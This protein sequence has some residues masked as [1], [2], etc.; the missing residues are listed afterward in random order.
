MRPVIGIVARSEENEN[1][2]SMLY[3]FESIRQSIIS[4]G[5]EPL[6]LL[7]PQDLDYCKTR[8]KDYPDFTNDEE[9]RM[10]KW[11]DM[12]DGIILPGGYKLTNFDR[13]VVE[14]AT[15]KDVP[16]LGI[17][18]GMQI[19]SCYRKDIEIVPIDDNHLNHKQES[20]EGVSHRVDIKKDSLLYDIL[21]QDSIM[22]N[23]FHKK[24][25][26]PNKYYEIIA[27]SEDGIIEAIQNK[28]NT[29]N[30]GVQWHPEKN[31]LTDD[32]SKKIM[33]AFIKYSKNKIKV[34]AQS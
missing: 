8:I 34:K 20:Q 31:Y 32:N 6:L 14:Y 18:L 5:G 29:F 26:T 7:P 24:Q 33:D 2:L 11:L 16:I 15:E 9:K 30:L 23:S 19:M 10:L 4:L 28:K 21:K 22:V 25:A 12:C 17:C 27:C 1:T 13:Y 3:V